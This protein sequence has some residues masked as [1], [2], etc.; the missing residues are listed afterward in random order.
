MREG[1]LRCTSLFM[2]PERPRLP[3]AFVDGIGGKADAEVI[4]A[5]FAF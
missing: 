4:G 1:L 3:C 2:A 5:H